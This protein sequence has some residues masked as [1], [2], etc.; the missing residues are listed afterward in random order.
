MGMLLGG[1]LILRSLFRAGHFD[2]D[3]YPSHSPC[4]I[5]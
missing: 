4:I 1:V 5:R 2:M 3:V